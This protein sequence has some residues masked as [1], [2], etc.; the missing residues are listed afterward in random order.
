MSSRN[1]DFSSP[2]T[3]RASIP[4]ENNQTVEEKHNV[5]KRNKSSDKSDDDDGKDDSRN[6]KKRVSIRGKP[7]EASNGV[8]HSSG[9]DDDVVS[10][11][12]DESPTTNVKKQPPATKGKPN[13]AGDSVNHSDDD[14]S[15]IEDETPSTVKKPPARRGTTKP[16][17]SGVSRNDNGKNGKTNTRGAVK[18]P[19]TTKGKAKSTG[20]TSSETYSDA[21]DKLWMSRFQLLQ[22]YKERTGSACVPRRHIEDGFELG[23]WVSIQRQSH[24][25]KKM[26]QNRLQMLLDIGFVWNAKLAASRGKTSPSIKAETPVVRRRR[27]SRTS[28]ASAATKPR[29]VAATNIRIGASNSTNTSGVKV[30]DSTQLLWEEVL[31]MEDSVRVIKEQLLHMVRE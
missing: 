23:S 3:G 26:P 8:K 30:N 27:R 10:S 2:R 22:K 14:D 11:S 5:K 17:G 13:A 29:T 25:L 9:D 31:K 24:K 4:L 1:Y 12:E 7:T 28:T 19:T 18:K 21:N 16:T 15:V 6:G 20:T